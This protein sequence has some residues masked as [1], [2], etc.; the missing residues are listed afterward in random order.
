MTNASILHDKSFPDATRARWLL[1]LLA[2]GLVVA[3]AGFFRLWRIDQ[4]PPG[5]GYDEAAY[6]H[7]AL[8]LLQGNLAP[9]YE[10][11]VL[12]SYLAAPFVALLGRTPVALRLP[13]A[14][15]GIVAAV[16]L[17]LYVRESFGSRLAALLA[18]LIYAVTF[19][20]VHVN[21]LGFPSNTL[22]LVQATTFYFFWR[23]RRRKQQGRGGRWS[24]AASGFFLGLAVQSYYAGLAIVAAMGLAWLGWLWGE[25]RRGLGAA[26]VF[27]AAFLIPTLPWLVV[28]APQVAGS[29]H[30]GG[31]FILNP[32]VHQG[33]PWQLFARQTLEHVGLFGFTGD[34]IWRH[35]LPGR[36]FFELPLALFFWGGVALALWRVRLAPYA[37]LLIQLVFGILPG[38]L[39]RTDTGPVFLHLTAM[40]VPA[41]VFPAL[42]ADWLVLQAGRW[43]RWAG[44]A[45]AALFCVLLAVTAYRTYVDY[46]Q[47]WA[48]GVAGTMSFD[49]LFVATA[50]LMNETDG[51]VDAWLLPMSGTA[52][53][54]GQA[55][56]LDFVYD[57]T[58][59]A[60]WAAAND[61]TAGATLQERLA[62]GQRVGLVT[63]DWEALKWAAPAYTDEKGLLRFLLAQNGRLVVQQPYDGFTVDIYELAASPSF[64]APH[65]PL[66][67]SAATFA[68]GSLALRG[69]TYGGTDGAAAAAG[70]P[71]ALTLSWEA[72]QPP[73]RDLKATVLLVDH[74]GHVL[75]QDDQ[76]LRDA[77]GATSAAWPAGASGL[78]VRLLALPAGTPPGAYKVQVAVYDAATLERLPVASGDRAGARVAIAGPLTLGSPD[79]GRQAVPSPQQP[80]TVTTGAPPR[81]LLAGYDVLPQ[82]AKPGDTL[83]LA[84]YWQALQDAPAAPT[85]RLELIDRASGASAQSQALELNDAY[86]PA[87]WTAGQYVADRSDVR[88]NRDLPSG[89]YAMQ[90]AI[91]GGDGVSQRVELGELA[92]AGWPR[93]FAPPAV[94]QPAAV[95]F[96]D[97]MQLVGYT[98][99]P[100]V[101]GEPLTVTLCWQALAEMDASYV[102]FVHLLDAEGRLVSQ[103][104]AVP[105][106]GAYPTTGWLPGETV[107]SEHVL[108]L[109]V[110]LPAG[111]YMLAAGVYDPLFEQRLLAASEG[112]PAGD[113]VTLT[114][115][116][117]TP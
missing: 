25:R 100:A 102:T 51:Q 83:T 96:G 43:R 31:Q 114:A 107:C 65:S 33:A 110:G 15:A 4:V 87:R 24:L 45:T 37:F 14:L 116:E 69:Y 30:T 64:D 99:G 20:A 12:H 16:M 19:G 48:Q 86:P 103:N 36:P 9:A 88:L 68:D 108:P 40:F 115:V 78:D 71:L 28:V 23:G 17:Y 112:L 11:G 2:I 111:V 27:W 26:V 42:A 117:L 74:A 35:N 29:P 41:C 66:Q 79:L 90:L 34:E 7:L 52:G 84:S 38:A 70:A 63:W 50:Q 39:A 95:R 59:P 67:P 92:I 58:T 73:G 60:I 76:F 104:D 81:L 106:Q 55:R 54:G 22:P 46:F 32:T 94:A 18:A 3:V 97:Q 72:N 56:S 89:V 8:Q 80:L 47:T 49:E 57:R 82:E 53:S 13:E 85:I 21:R 93:Q 98:V 5:L 77:A 109:D 101:A 75:V 91:D 105:G 10:L 44:A 61:A 1:E 6:G 62:G 113:E